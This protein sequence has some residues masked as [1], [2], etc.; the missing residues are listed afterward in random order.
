[1]IWWCRSDHINFSMPYGQIADLT[2]KLCIAK[3]AK[4]YYYYYYYYYYNCESLNHVI[5]QAVDWKTQKLPELA[6]ALHDIIDMV[7]A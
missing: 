4:C 7:T 1:M 6:Q 5:K 2:L 3:T